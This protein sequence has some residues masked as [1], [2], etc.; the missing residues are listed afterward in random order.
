MRMVS[1]ETNSVLKFISILFVIPIFIGFF[2]TTPVYGGGY[3][4]GTK[5]EE[6]L[7]NGEVIFGGIGEGYSSNVE[8]YVLE[9]PIMMIKYQGKLY[10]CHVTLKI[11]LKVPQKEDGFEIH[12]WGRKQ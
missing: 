1:G 8:E 2:I 10:R 11:E 3:Y 9:N 7:L 4:G 6:I 5:G 12:C